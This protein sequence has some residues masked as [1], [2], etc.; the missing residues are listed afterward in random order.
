MYMRIIYTRIYCTILCLYTYTNTCIYINIGMAPGDVIELAKRC[1][2]YCRMKTNANITHETY[3]NITTN[4]NSSTSIYTPTHTPSRDD[5]YTTPQKN[6][7]NN[8]NNNVDSPYTKHI[9]SPTTTS[10]TTHTHTTHAYTYT[11]TYKYILTETDFLS[12]YTNYVTSSSTDQKSS[13]GTSTSTGTGTG[14]VNK[15]KPV[16]WS[17]IGGYKKQIKQL[18]DVYLL[19]RLYKRVF[20]YSPISLSTAALLYGPTGCGGS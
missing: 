3:D 17:Q 15:A 14:I 13:S 9:H 2:Q 1:A 12:V 6:N 5:M 16:K 20:K 18:T 7:N 4:N 10:P 8:T 19:P 11:N